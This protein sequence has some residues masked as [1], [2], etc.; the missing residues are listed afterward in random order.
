MSLTVIEQA[1]AK[2]NLCLFLGGTRED[3]RH[4]LVT[5]FDS[6]RLADELIVREVP[7]A[8]GDEVVCEGVSGPNLVADALA[9]LRAAGWAAPPVHVEIWKRIPVA[10]G[11]GGGSADAAAMLRCAPRMAPVDPA[12]L[13]PLAASLGADVPGQLRPGPSL[14][15]GAG[16]TIEPLPTL[17]GY[18][19]LVLPAPFALSTADVYR[20]AD[21]L[22]LGRPADELERRRRA[23]AAALGPAGT[24]D[25]T[26]R[27]GSGSSSSG[28]EDPDRGHPA[29]LP[30]EMA[31]ND[32]QPA[33]LSLR[34]ELAVALDDVR[35]AGAD[36]ALVCGSGPTVIGLFHGADG[37][38]RARRAAADPGLQARHPRALATRPV[39]SAQSGRRP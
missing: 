36:R 17:A 26:D 8:A 29:A 4:E 18:G 3:G 34:P 28:D 21:R 27:T 11:M 32:L 19:V 9:G 37:G 22:G 14:G 1:Y 35:A 16:E 2:L 13:A 6:V 38:E 24:T 39:H 20:E 7:G 23:L 31:V 12:A 5:V 30:E 15:T 33:A 25:A 10:A